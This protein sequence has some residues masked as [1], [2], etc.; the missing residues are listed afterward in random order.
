MWLVTLSPC[1]GWDKI[2]NRVHQSFE[3][4]LFVKFHLEMPGFDPG[5]SACKAW[6]LPLISTASPKCNK[7]NV[8]AALPLILDRVV[9]VWAWSQDAQLQDKHRVN[10]ENMMGSTLSCSDRSSGLPESAATPFQSALNSAGDFWH[11]IDM[12]RLMD[13]PP[14]GEMLTIRFYSWAAP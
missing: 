13:S 6:P 9:K 14:S 12:R 5:G 2:A 1:S 3:A 4:R 8:I 10:S 11:L 7:L